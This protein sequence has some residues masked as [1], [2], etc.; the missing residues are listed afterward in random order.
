VRNGYLIA[1]VLAE[2]LAAPPVSQG[3]GDSA[4]GIWLAHNVLVELID[5]LPGLEHVLKARHEDGL[6]RNLTREWLT[7]R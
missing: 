6:L 5:D 1:E 2:L 4:L 7:N 3:D